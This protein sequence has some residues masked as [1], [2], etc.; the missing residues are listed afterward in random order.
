[1]SAQNTHIKIA[2]ISDTHIGFYIQRDGKVCPDTKK[3]NKDLRGQILEDVKSYEPDLVLFT[4][5]LLNHTVYKH[6]DEKQGQ[7]AIEETKKFVEDI[8]KG[9]DVYYF[10][11]PGNHDI[12]FKN[13]G[14]CFG[15]KSKLKW[16]ASSEGKIESEIQNVIDNYNKSIFSKYLEIFIKPSKI[17]LKDYKGLV[18]LHVITVNQK[19]IAIISINNSWFCQLGDDTNQLYL[20]RQ[21]ANKIKEELD[22]LNPDLIIGIMHHP[23]SYYNYRERLKSN[24][25]F[26]SFKKLAD[27]CDYIFQGH[28]HLQGLPA[29]IDES[30]YRLKEEYVPV[31]CGALYFNKSWYLKAQYYLVDIDINAKR[32]VNPNK[33]KH[34]IIDF[35]DGDINLELPHSDFDIWKKLLVARIDAFYPDLKKR[36]S[37]PDKEFIK[38]NHN[39]NNFYFDELVKEHYK[40]NIK[41]DFEDDFPCNG[42]EIEIYPQDFILVRE[43]MVEK[44]LSEIFDSENR[45]ENEEQ[46]NAIENIKIYRR[47]S[48]TNAFAKILHCLYQKFGKG[49]LFLLDKNSPAQI[50]LN[51]NSEVM[52]DA[53][54][55]KENYNYFKD[56]RVNFQNLTNLKININDK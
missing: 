37:D 11:C 23:E 56:F 9:V 43:C 21:I 6:S 7:E 27:Y 8:T 32:I 30:T 28:T 1:M 41:G 47:I 33:R 50:T 52:A 29:D 12:V 5:D 4:G 44:Y 35:V 22:K 49:K 14:P 53:E 54:Y 10:F 20:G 55:V 17:E 46:K 36:L 19:E 51:I 3:L 45:P 25:E 18:D 2:H 26:G 16:D 31:D 24:P 39:V 15:G 34:R 42:K 48:S 38:I 40:R 13:I